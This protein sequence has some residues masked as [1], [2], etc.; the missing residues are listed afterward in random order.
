MEAEWHYDNAYANA[1]KFK[2][3]AGNHPREYESLFANLEKIVRLLQGGQKIGGFQVGFFRSEGEGVYRVGQT[4]VPGAKE[5]RLYIYFYEQDRICYV[6]NIGDKDSQSDDINEA[7][8]AASQIKAA[9]TQKKDEHK[10]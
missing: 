9:T 10:I 6:L 2:K 3:F 4:G 7:K 5:S 1:R 8:Q